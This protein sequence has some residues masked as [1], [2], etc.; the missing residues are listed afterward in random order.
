MLDHDR[1]WHVICECAPLAKTFEAFLLADFSLAEDAANKAA[2]AG[3]LAALAPAPPPPEVPLEAPSAAILRPKKFFAPH[4]IKRAVTVKPLLTPDDY[5]KPILDLMNNA[6][7]RFYMQTQYIKVAG[8]SD[9]ADPSGT[10]HTDLLKGLTGMIGRGLD[11]RLITSEFQDKTA[12]EALLSDGIDIV[13]Q[14]RIQTGVHNKGMVVDSKIAV[15]SSQNWSGLGTWKN[16]DAGL[17]MFDV[18]AARYFEEIFLHDWE[19]LAIQA[20][21]P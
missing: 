2:A 17:I 5:R 11:V 9:P 6:T 3:G 12:L 1:D 13:D 15:V 4:V 8:K 18:E 16:R 14:L 20:V 7:T 10:T 21:R 19:N